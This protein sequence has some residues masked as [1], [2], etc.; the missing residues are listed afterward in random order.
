[1][2]A[3]MLPTGMG[4]KFEESGVRREQCYGCWWGSCSVI[5]WVLLQTLR[6]SKV[7]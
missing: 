5:F 6:L 4:E 3:G 7:P 1:M 2:P